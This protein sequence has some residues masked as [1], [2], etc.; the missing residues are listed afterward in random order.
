MRIAS[1]EAI[2]AGNA[3]YARVVG[4]DGT[5]GVG[6]STFFAWPTAVAEIV[7]SIG[8][9]LEGR[10][11]FDL[12]HHWLTLYRALSFRGMA[13]TGAISAVDQALWDL[14]GKHFGVPVW[15]L[16][17]GRA[18]TAVRAMKVLVDEGPIDQLVESARRAVDD[19]GYSALKI[20]L[21]QSEHHMMRQAA[22]IDDL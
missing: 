14:K 2:P 22:R 10:D 6:E 11:A 17:G 7:R 15:Q 19:E 16:L 21:F 4:D 5:S 8:A 13:V 9:S 3:C 18:R 20:L 1:V 12:E